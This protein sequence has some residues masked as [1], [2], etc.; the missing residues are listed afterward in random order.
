MTPTQGTAEGNSAQSS[1]SKPSHQDAV[2]SEVEEELDEF[3]ASSL[4]EQ[5]PDTLDFE[6][7]ADPDVAYSAEL[8]PDV[9]AVDSVMSASRKQQKAD[10]NSNIRRMLEERSEARQLQQDL[11][12]LD[13]D[14]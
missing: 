4:T 12:Y 1:A 14:D 7:D 3:G 6:E 11:D 8:D 2:S 5:E 13:F 9:A 10:K